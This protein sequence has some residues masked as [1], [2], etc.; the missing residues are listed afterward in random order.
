[1]I[2]RKYHDTT[3]RTHAIWLVLLAVL[4]LNLPSPWSY[5]AD[6]N[7]RQIYAKAA[8]AVVFVYASSEGKAMM[9]TG[10]IIH[11]DGYVVTNAH[12]VTDKETG[13]PFQ[14][15]WI[16]FKP[17]QPVGKREEDLKRWNNAQVVALDLDLDLALLK[18]EQP[19]LPLAVLPFGDSSAIQI[20][21][22]V[23][24]I[25]HPESGGLWSLTTGVISANHADFNQVPGKHVFQTETGL[26]RGNS[27]GPLLDANGRQVGVNTAIARKSAA[28]GLAITSI[29]FSIKS[30]VVQSWL[31]KQGVKIQLASEA[32]PLLSAH[33]APSM[34]AK[35]PEAE[36]PPKQPYNVDELVRDLSK[37]ERDLTSQGDD[38]RRR[39]QNL[40]EGGS[41]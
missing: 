5:A 23:A 41:P 1:M 21:D 4:A 8:P 30:R 36:L 32:V 2:Q 26:N 34:E 19:P 25:G 33:A 18:L 28:D 13:Q 17:A 20:G 31:A 29:S 10:S 7:H 40:L 15:V 6:L 35:K 37:L 9:G 14:K 16:A 24:A 22:H 38:S 11:G 27:G 39:I 12:V 3:R